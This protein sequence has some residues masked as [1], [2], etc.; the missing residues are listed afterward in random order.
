MVSKEMSIAVMVSDSKK[1]AK[2]FEDSVGFRSSVEGHWVLVWPRGS[3]AKIH[4]CEGK[5]DPGNTGIAF[6]V[7]DAPAK[8]QKMKA[9]GVKFSR[10][11]KKTQWGT[12]GMFADADGN[13]YYLME[14]TGP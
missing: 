9:K 13:E 8:A 3:S 11:V 6:Y 1:S 10:E 7:K 12:N 4:L 2:W 14:G 5:P